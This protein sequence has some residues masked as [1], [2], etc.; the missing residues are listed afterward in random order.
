[1]TQKTNVILFIPPQKWE[2]SRPKPPQ[3]REEVGVL[4]HLIT[5][6]SIVLLFT[7]K[8]IYQEYALAC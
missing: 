3:I 4:K 1:M 6:T 8:Y 5:T 2:E 7:L